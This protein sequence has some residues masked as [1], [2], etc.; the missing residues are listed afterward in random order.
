VDAIKDNYGLVMFYGHGAMI[1]KQCMKAVGGFKEVVSE[2]FTFCL[3]ARKEGFYT[4]MASNVLT[5][6]D[7]PPNFKAFEKRQKK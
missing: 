4:A 7:N 5:R 1:S 6:D 3:D 2:D